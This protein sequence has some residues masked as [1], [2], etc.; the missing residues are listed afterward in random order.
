MKNLSQEQF[1]KIIEIIQK[2]LEPYKDF[3]F[4]KYRTDSLLN[5]ELKSFEIRVE[6]HLSEFTDL[7]DE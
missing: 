2:D 6:Q 5:S 1:H 3:L 4:Y 7:D